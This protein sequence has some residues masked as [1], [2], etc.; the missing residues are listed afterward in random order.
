[1]TSLVTSLENLNSKG[2]GV[3][4]ECP[5]MNP[6]SV[7]GSIPWISSTEFKRILSQ[8]NNL[9][10]FVSLLRE[11]NPGQVKVDGDGKPRVLYTPSKGDR[12]MLFQGVEAMA[13]LAFTAGAVK[14][15][16]PVAGMPAWDRPNPRSKPI[17]TKSDG[18]ESFAVGH[19]PPITPAG[20]PPPPTSEKDHTAELSLE[21][22][23]SKLRRHCGGPVSSS[24]SKAAL[25]VQ[26]VQYA[27]AH[28]MSTCRM[29]G[30]PKLG[31][32][33]EDG[34]VR[35]TRNVWC[36]DASVLPSASGVN[37]MISVLGCG[38]WVARRCLESVEREGG[39]EGK[40]RVGGEGGSE[41]ERWPGEDLV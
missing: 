6:A 16:A 5:A 21:T 23:L 3:R 8:F 33:D 40:K 19:A 4:I 18:P 1:M 13:R 9:G 25:P 37:P 29:S 17:S 7:L 20:Y 31:V 12:E 26:G 11:S 36:A 30:D 24:S 32:C 34:K 41:N 38:E 35:G 22:W 10:A 14:I 27:S 39:L 28:Q 2:Q 15:F